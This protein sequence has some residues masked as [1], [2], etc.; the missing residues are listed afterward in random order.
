[1]KCPSKRT[2]R[3]RARIQKYVEQCRSSEMDFAWLGIM[4]LAYAL[5]VGRQ[6]E[7]VG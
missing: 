5:W 1:M 6:M 4:C 3:T 7:Q 2:L